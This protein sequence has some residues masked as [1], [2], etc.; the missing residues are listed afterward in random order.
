MKLPKTIEGRVT[1]IHSAIAASPNPC[2]PVEHRRE[3]VQSLHN[4][5]SKAF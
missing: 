5:F 1:A 2:H 4:I 3:N